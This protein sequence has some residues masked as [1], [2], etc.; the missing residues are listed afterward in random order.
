M[1]ERD[2]ELSALLNDLRALS[3]RQS[4]AVFGS[5][6]RF[7][8]V[9]IQALLEAVPDDARRV[10][11]AAIFSPP[12]AS[13]IAAARGDA[14]ERGSCHLTDATRGRLLD[15][16]EQARGQGGGVSQAE[17]PATA[18]SLMSILAAFVAPVLGSR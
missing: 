2:E 8:R 3:A 14:I 7:E 11:P 5:L 13:R 1:P 18:K 6:T 15:L 4:R 12:V 10:E 17:H 16:A 9:R